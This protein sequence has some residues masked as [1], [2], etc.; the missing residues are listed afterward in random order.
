MEDSFKSSKEQPTE[1]DPINI[2]TEPITSEDQET[3]HLYL[4]LT[5]TQL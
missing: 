4:I 3:W 5:K 2:E 1:K